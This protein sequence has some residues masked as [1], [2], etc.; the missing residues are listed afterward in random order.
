MLHTRKAQEVPVLQ[1]NEQTIR[2]MVAANEIS[3][4]NR[5][6]AAFL[7]ARFDLRS[8]PE[9]P[10]QIL[11]FASGISL[12]SMELA[13]HAAQVVDVEIDPIAVTAAR[14]LI[15]GQGLTNIQVICQRMEDFGDETVWEQSRPADR[16]MDEVQ[17]VMELHVTDRRATCRPVTDRRTS[18]RPV[19]DRPTSDRRRVA[20]CS[21]FG[22][23]DE[24]I[25]AAE[26]NG[27]DELIYIARQT[28]H[29]RFSL[30]A[31]PWHSHKLAPKEQLSQLA[32]RGYTFT[33]TPH[34]ADFGQPF[35]DQRDLE[36]FFETYDQ[37]TTGEE[38]Q[39]ALQAVRERLVCRD[40]PDWPF[41]YPMMKQS[42]IYHGRLQPWMS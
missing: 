13:D 1:W 15:A 20:L 21:F 30:H 22:S 28:E 23:L 39:A 25:Q 29:R 17:P 19:K 10:L 7:E 12:L 31:D 35:A 18:D 5:R 34:E 33:C 27:C 16:G 41:Y 36:R 2:W 32:A 42:H 11:E 3:G 24:V 38:R 40:D 8:K 4:Y 6:L 14:R 9:A 37:K 26:A